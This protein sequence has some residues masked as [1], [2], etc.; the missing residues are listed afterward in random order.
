MLV[1]FNSKFILV[2]SFDKGRNLYLFD[3]PLETIIICNIITDGLPCLIEG[4]ELG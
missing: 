1:L 4:E 3:V 2:Y